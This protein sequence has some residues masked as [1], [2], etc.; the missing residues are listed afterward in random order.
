SK[1]RHVLISETD[2]ARIIGDVAPAPAVDE[3]AE[4]LTF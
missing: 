2:L 1:A 4:D 3:P